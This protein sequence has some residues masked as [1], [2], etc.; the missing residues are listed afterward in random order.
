[1]ALWRDNSSPK[2]S[3]QMR[4]PPGIP[5]DSEDDDESDQYGSD[6]MDIDDYGDVDSHRHA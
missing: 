2:V 4:G 3:S 5:Y 1:M 6:E